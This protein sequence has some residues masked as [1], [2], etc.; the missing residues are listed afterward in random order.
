MYIKK[1][2]TNIYL[3]VIELQR[4]EKVQAA[5]S[6]FHKVN[7]NKNWLKKKKKKKTFL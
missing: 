6:S 4:M 1:I 3:Y 7:N 2:I 5:G